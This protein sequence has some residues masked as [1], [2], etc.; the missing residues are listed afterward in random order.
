MKTP[1]RVEPLQSITPIGTMKKWGIDLI[2][3]LSRTAE[4]NQWLIVAI[5]YSTKWPEARAV[6]DKRA[7]TIA[8]F[9]VDEI[10]CRHGVPSEI[11]TDQGTEF[12]NQLFTHIAEKA[13]MKHI[14]TTPYHPQANG[15]V[16]RMNQTL[17]AIMRKLVEDMENTWDEYVNQ[18][19]FAY[20]TTRQSTTKF[21]PFYLLNGYEA[22]TPVNKQ[23]AQIGTEKDLTKRLGQIT[24]LLSKRVQARKNIR[25]R[26]RIQKK[27]YDQ[28][29]MGP[30][31]IVGDL[32]WIDKK[33]L[34]R[35]PQDKMNPKL[36]GPFEIIRKNK[37]GTYYLKDRKTGFELKTAYSADK[38]RKYVI[39]RRWGEPL[40][41]IE[42]MEGIHDGTEFPRQIGTSD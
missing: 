26:Q 7:E 21:T 20:R 37:N 14:M 23:L 9:V 18:A 22:V 42:E 19:L 33:T 41:E 15:Q 6:R 17:V 12:N 4:G 36:E 1:Q 29:L 35:I 3:P 38:F 5:D 32:V 40:I 11:V 8:S 34:R 24:E 30:S 27:Y 31:Y 16:E 25:E 13:H 10:I 2:G 39:Q 28:G